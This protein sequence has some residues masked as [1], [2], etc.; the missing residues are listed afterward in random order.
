LLA[1]AL[2]N[3][4]TFV[5]D[6]QEDVQSLMQRVI[7]NSNGYDRHD[8]PWNT[9][10]SWQHSD[11]DILDNAKRFLI[12]ATTT[13]GNGKHLSRPRWPAPLV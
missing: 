1:L 7:A 10:T 8:R 3:Y 9:P 6:A 11:R 4:G 5:S 2:V 13:A 12:E